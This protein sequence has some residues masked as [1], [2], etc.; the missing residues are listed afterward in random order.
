MNQ[1]TAVMYAA[2]PMGTTSGR[3]RAQAVASG[4]SMTGISDALGNVEP[5]VS[6]QPI[7]YDVGAGERRA[8]V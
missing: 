4:I 5:A 8:L 3:R 7:A 1:Y 2:T 6:Q